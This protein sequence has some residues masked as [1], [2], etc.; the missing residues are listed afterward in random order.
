M[1]KRLI[2]KSIHAE[3]ERNAPPN[4]NHRLSIVKH[5]SSYIIPASLALKPN[6][7]P[8]PDPLLVKNLSPN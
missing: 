8:L 7:L 3:E 5:R 2:S 4:T 1:T 6:Y